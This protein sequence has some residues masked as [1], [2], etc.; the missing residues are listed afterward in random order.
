MLCPD[1][2]L[3]V[4][5]F[6]ALLLICE[7]R[8]VL[9]SDGKMNCTNCANKTNNKKMELW[10]IYDENKERTGRTMKHNDWNMKP[11]ECQPYKQ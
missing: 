11:G 9:D 6:R 1:Q 3:R 4:S 10:D 5:F 7:K 2:R 8:K